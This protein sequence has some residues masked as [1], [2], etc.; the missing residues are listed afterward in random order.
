MVQAYRQTISGRGIKTVEMAFFGGSFT[1]MPVKL[2]SEYLE[3]AQHYKKQGVID[4]IRLST[5]PDYID[6]QIL[7]FLKSYAV[8]II[9]LGVQSFNDDVLAL[10]KRGHG[11]AVIY[12]SA[13]LIKE[14]GF[15]LGIQL[16]IGLPGDSPEK[17]AYS[18]RKT[19]EL[20]PEIA[21]IYPTMVIR[22]TA[23]C[24]MYQQG[25]YQIWPLA[26]M[27]SCAGAMCRILRGAG[28]NVIRI[29]L[30]S[31]DNI[32]NG[33]DV[34]GNNY[35]PA[36]RQLVESELAK[37]S[38]E[39]QLNVFIKRDKFM[40]RDK[41]LMEPAK[42]RDKQYDKQS[43]AVF[44][45][46]KSFSNMIGHKASN[47]KYFNASYPNGQ[48]EYKVDESIPDNIYVVKKIGEIK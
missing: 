24:E 14:Y 8:D 9:E 27:V 38:I 6:E 45:N 3:I 23:L 13:A 29:G 20:R 22:D 4:K 42:Q 19:A 41:P 44:S 36:F 43:V 34:L 25:T 26:E 48:F 15:T 39:E 31:T 35:H 17:A 46:T 5:R 30:K 11:S 47:K 33:G 16:M 7:D 32:A 21:R 28:V 37:E 40:K 18:A 10:S 2:Q 12:K 1:G